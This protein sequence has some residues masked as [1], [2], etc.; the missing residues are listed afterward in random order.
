[1]KYGHS[2]WLTA[3]MMGGC[4]AAGYC[5]S[6]PN[7]ADNAAKTASN[8]KQTVKAGGKQATAS[9]SETA[10]GKAILWEDRGTLTPAQVFWGAASREQNPASRL[11]TPPFTN[12][13]KDN[14]GTS[15][16]CRM[17][18][19]NGIKW[20][21]KFGPEVHAD[22]A[23]PRLA[24]A[25]GYGVDENYYVKTGRIYGIGADT[26]LGKCKGYIAPDGTFAEARFKRHDK[27]EKHLKGA[28]NSKANSKDEDADAD[29]DERKNPGVP[30]EQLSGLL[31]LEVMVHDWDAQPK[32]NK[33]VQTA[34]ADGPQNWYIVSDWG[35][36][37]G[38]MK[39]K[40]VL[41]DYRKE[42]SF[43]RKVDGE[44]VYLKFEDI[45]KN[46]AAVHEKIPLAHAQWFRKQLARLTDADIRA[47]FQAAYASE[48]VTKAYAGGS[49]ADSAAFDAL[50]VDTIEGYT[51][52]FRAKINEFMEKV[53]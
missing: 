49:V 38:Q 8:T 7:T 22:V 50:T 40:G 29:W 2:S 21:V 25:L 34:G 11:P 41:S 33:I 6:A 32:N 23:A 37:F 9:P 13:E 44:Y 30:P 15:P 51:Q 10:A 31:I 20:T 3:G 48:D 4:I 1:M 36:S 18:D 24:W 39:S 12:F 16:K 52:A 26:D 53:Q 19:K 43:V 45:I 46:M 27:A 35:A 17:T 5:Q 47:A 14:D 42:T 28:A